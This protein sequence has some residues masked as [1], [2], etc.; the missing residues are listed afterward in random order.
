MG[1]I[2]IVATLNGIVVHIILISRV[3]FGMARQGNM[4]APFARVS[5]SPGRRCWRPR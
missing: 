3:L 2:A 5:R 4:P 1:A